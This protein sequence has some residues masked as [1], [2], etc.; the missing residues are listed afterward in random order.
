MVFKSKR[1][2]SKQNFVVAGHITNFL[3]PVFRNI[4]V[5]EKYNR[6]VKVNYE[7]EHYVRVKFCGETK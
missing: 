2:F 6:S 5:L 7:S 4:F 1:I 3:I